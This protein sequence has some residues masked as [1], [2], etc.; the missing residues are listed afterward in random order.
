MCIEGILRFF[1]IF[2]LHR[3][4]YIF[5]RN[6]CD[7]KAVVAADIFETLSWLW[8]CCFEGILW[9]F[10]NFYLRRKVSI[11][12]RNNRDWKDIDLY[13]T[14]KRYT[15]IERSDLMRNISWLASCF[16]KIKKPNKHCSWNESVIA[17]VC[18]ID[19]TAQNKKINTIDSPFFHHD[20]NGSKQRWRRHHEAT[21]IAML[22]FATT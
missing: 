4:F 20:G 2:Y 7:F 11:F 18:I 9:L 19:T 17:G 1:T 14:R 8:N 3:K 5:L 21:T 15:V 12:L 10:T 6:D 22:S 16:S 13:N